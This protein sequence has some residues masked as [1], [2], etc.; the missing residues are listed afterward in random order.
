[1]SAPSL[2]MPIRT[3]AAR[4]IT[5]GLSSGEGL[6]WEIRDPI[7]G[8]EKKT[9]R[10]IEVDPG[11]DDKRVLVIESEFGNV[12]RVLTRDGNTLSAVMRLAWDGDDLRTMTKNN[13]GPGDPIPTSALSA[14]S[15]HELAKYLSAVEVFNGLG[16]RLPVGLRSAGQRAA[17]RRV[18][19]SS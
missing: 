16:N 5:H 6:I 2:P 1:M 10:S 18:L 3:W 17:V 13:P 8:T 11:V 14:T 9:G 19:Q 4:K 12:L 15:R 7:F